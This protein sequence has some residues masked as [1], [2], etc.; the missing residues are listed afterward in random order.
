M[1]A[2][3]IPSGQALAHARHKSLPSWNQ[4]LVCNFF[5]NCN[6]L[7]A[8]PLL[9]LLLH[10]ST[11][12]SPTPRTLP[13]HSHLVGRR[14]ALLLAASHTHTHTHPQTASLPSHAASVSSL[15]LCIATGFLPFHRKERRNRLIGSRAQTTRGVFGHKASPARWHTSHCW[16]VLCSVTL[17]DC[18]SFCFPISRRKGS[19]LYY[20]PRSLV[21]LSIG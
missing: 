11:L 2:T 10:Y 8:P 1:L 7:P 5:Y 9:L 15:Y 21:L 20:V 19:V 4:D 14:L 18:S 6:A 13:V 17:L 12:C 3:H 16:A